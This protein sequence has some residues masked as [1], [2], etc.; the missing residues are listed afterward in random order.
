MTISPY[1]RASS[2]SLSFPILDGSSRSFTNALL[3]AAKLGRYES[4]LRKN[5]VIALNDLNFEFGA[6]TRLGIVGHNGAGKSTL[7]RMIAG[8]Y[9]PT[10]G[11]YESAGRIASFIDIALGVMPDATG[12]ENILT[13]ALLWGMTRAEIS[14]KFDAIVEFSELGRYIDLPVRTYSSGMQMRLAF[15]VAIFVDAEILLMDEWLS[16]GDQDFKEKAQAML[17]AK[18]AKSEL[19][20]IATHSRD[21]LARLTDTVLQLEGGTVI[22]NGPTA[23]YLAQK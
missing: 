8:I 22:F 20:V 16:V 18:V 23:D 3:N 19:F 17:K 12:R 13:R 7:L 2:A 9:Q 15:S 11:T 14:E 4:N 5:E 1:I 21:S 6:G 10:A